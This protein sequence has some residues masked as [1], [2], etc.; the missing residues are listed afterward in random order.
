MPH[1]PVTVG[2]LYGL[3]SSAAVFGIARAATPE[4]VT[5]ISIGLITALAGAWVQIRKQRQNEEVI[6]ALI[7]QLQQRTEESSLHQQVQA[8]AETTARQQQ[9]R[10]VP[11][12][13]AKPQG[14]TDEWPGKEGQK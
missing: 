2:S 11:S 9:Q 4:G 7:E 12:P 13:P 8:D 6:H 5:A 14:M 1:T 10:R 3:A